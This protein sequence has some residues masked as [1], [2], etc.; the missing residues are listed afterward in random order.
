MSYRTYLWERIKGELKNSIIYLEIIGVIVVVIGF[1][2]VIVY[3]LKSIVDYFTPIFGLMR[4][5]CIG[6]A[7][8]FI[9]AFVLILIVDYKDYIKHRRA[10]RNL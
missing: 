5:F 1:V 10:G 9:G 7:V 3:T 8:L 4:A 6:I 2:L